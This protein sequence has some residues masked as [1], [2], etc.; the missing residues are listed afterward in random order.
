MRINVY[1]EEL[2]Y[3]SE[4]VHKVVDGR[5]FYGIRMFLES[6]S[7]LHHTHKDDDRSAITLWVPWTSTDGND[8]SKL[9]AILG[10]LKEQAIHLAEVGERR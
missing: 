3:Q 9:I 6:T 8:F 2:T 1:A 5:N 10:G 4:I 7:F